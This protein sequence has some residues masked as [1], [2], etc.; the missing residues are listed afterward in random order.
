MLQ[1]LHDAL[2]V[3]EEECEKN[4]LRAR[5]MAQLE[6]ASDAGGLTGGKARVELTAMQVVM[7]H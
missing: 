1:K 4:D 5:K 7:T 3:W 2:E 6:V